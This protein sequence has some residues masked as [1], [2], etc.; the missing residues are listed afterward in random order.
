MTAEY[1]LVAAFGL[2]IA[3]GLGFFLGRR[4]A[5]TQHEVVAAQKERDEACSEVDRVRGEVTR[6]FEES[7]TM[8]GRLA[9]DY[10]TF[11]EQFAQTAQN[12]GLSEGRARELL[13]QADP[14]LVSEQ[15]NSAAPAGDSPVESP[16]AVRG[17]ADS[18]DNMPIGFEAASPQTVGGEET[19]AEE[20]APALDE[21]PAAEDDDKATNEEDERAGGRSA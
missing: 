1:W 8:F 15:A 16:E 10:R 11:F 20:E 13:Q 18:D 9:D 3:L 12:L 7:A 21:E 4:T 6:H 14:R 17:S 19:L 5:P 2:A